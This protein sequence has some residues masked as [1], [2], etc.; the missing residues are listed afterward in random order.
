MGPREPPPG[1]VGSRDPVRFAFLQ[2]RRRWRASPPAMPADGD[3]SGAGLTAILRLPRNA[4]VFFVVFVLKLYGLSSGLKFTSI[5]VRRSRCVG[6]LAW[7]SS[8]RRAEAG[9]HATSASALMRG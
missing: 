9:V 2:R 5:A 7:K 3:E 4:F 6:S 8:T 1:R